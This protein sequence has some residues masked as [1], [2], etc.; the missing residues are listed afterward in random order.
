MN[1]LCVLLAS[2]QLA[3]N[4]GEVLF[5]YRYKDPSAPV[6]EDDNSSYDNDDSLN[7]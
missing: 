6:V 1:Y 5:S 4:I 7:L 2:P 3:I